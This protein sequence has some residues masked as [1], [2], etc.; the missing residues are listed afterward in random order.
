MA[1]FKRKEKP[2]ALITVST[3]QSTYVTPE[4]KRT[5]ICPNCGSELKKVPG[6]K[7]KCPGCSRYVYVRM[8]PRINARVVV[9]EDQ[10][11][12]IDDAI[13]VANGTW[14]QRKAEKEHR[15]HAVAALTEQFGTTP[16]DADVNWRMW[17][18]DF[19]AASATRDTYTMFSVS[20]K[21]M[22]QLG[23]EKKYPD[24]IVVAARGI[25]MNWADFNHEVLPAWTT[26][27]E[28][29]IK[30]GTSLTEAHVLFVKG[31]VAVATIPKY[32]VNVDQVWKDVMKILG[33]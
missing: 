5:N 4:D 29:A 3:S 27:I 16:N 17:N 7:T 22:D 8:D 11:D 26:C 12:E 9:G 24:A 33:N 18:E 1:W 2:S 32:Q 6:A 31:A 20:W 30:N 23:R 25:I 15:A 19:L 13:A 14:E 21:M 28:K 10:I